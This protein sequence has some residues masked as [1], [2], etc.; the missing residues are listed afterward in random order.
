GG[1]GQPSSP[2]PGG[3]SWRGILP[4]RAGA[5]GDDHARAETKEGADDG[6]LKGEGPR[7]GKQRS[8]PKASPLRSITNCSSKTTKRDA[9]KVTQGRSEQLQDTNI[10]EEEEE[11]EEEEQEEDGD[12]DDEDW[13]PPT[14]TASVS[15]DYHSPRSL[16]DSLESIMVGGKRPRTRRGKVGTPL[17]E[18][19]THR[20]SRSRLLSP[21]IPVSTTSFTGVQGFA[22]I[23]NHSMEGFSTGAFSDADSDSSS[24]LGLPRHANPSPIPLCSAREEE[25]IPPSISSS[26]I[27]AELEHSPDLEKSSPGENGASESIIRGRGTKGRGDNRPGVPRDA[28]GLLP[29]RGV[30]DG[31]WREATSSSNSDSRQRGSSGKGSTAEE[32]SPLWLQEPELPDVPS[33]LEQGAAAGRSGGGGG[34]GCNKVTHTSQRRRTR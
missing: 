24:N 18:D 22:G 10:M 5:G 23:H 31:A 8:S 7:R 15:V 17:T 28:P 13:V 1:R 3:L 11:E 26:L 33:P 29:G 21:V 34:G 27:N 12:D 6:A 30:G 16:E 4:S 14:P 19:G 9:S 32:S 25:D 20:T 2:S